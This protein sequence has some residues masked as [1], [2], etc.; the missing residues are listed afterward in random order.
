MSRTG[1]RRGERG[2]AL[3]VVLWVFMILGVLALDFARY[4]RDDA[5]AT[6]N[7]AEETRGYYVALAG[8]NHVIFDAQQ[9][10]DRSLGVP[11]STDDNKP[12]LHMK[13]DEDEDENNI[14][15]DGQ[16][17][18][19][20]F[21]GG[22]YQVRLTDEGG[23]I[24]LNRV[25]DLI[26]TE[27]VTN[28]LRGGNKTKGMNVHETQAVAEIV[29]AILDWRDVDNLKRLHGA[30]NEYYLSLK[31]PYHAKQGWFDSPEELLLVRGITP[32]LYYGG[33]GVPGLRDVFSV[34]SRSGTVNVKTAPA[35]VLQALLGIEAADVK[36]LVDLRDADG[37]A[38]ASFVQSQAT[39]GDPRIAGLL[40]AQEPS[41]VT[42]EA[43]ADVSDPRN[44][45]RVE[46]VADLSSEVAEGAKI[47]RWIDRAPWSGPL[48]APE[49]EQ[50]S[51]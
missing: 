49:T 16:W 24:A 39:S 37:D 28:L 29:D 48:P 43:R 34:Y 35:A 40:V 5:M 51:S 22:K 9:A 26:L 19:G 18:D 21:A 6:V 4:M 15:A 27:V 17:H 1:R 36:E 8:M 13:D 10:R 23:R 30:E 44:Q 11:A 42:I 41:I 14:P 12:G 45:S 25:D 3:L 47:I 32:E 38:F 31:H 50:E 20:T 2:V 46:A 33:D 7:F